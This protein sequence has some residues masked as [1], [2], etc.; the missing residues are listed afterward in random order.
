MPAAADPKGYYRIM[1]VPPTAS[2]EDIRIAFRERAKIF[3]PDQGNERANGDQFRL[4][5][6]A[7]D[8]LRDARKRMQYDAERLAV[9]EP[10][11]P[12]RPRA[13]VVVERDVNWLFSGRTLSLAA[14]GLAV[15]CLVLL[16]LLWS[17][18]NRLAERDAEADDLYRRL[19]AA[20]QDQAD[21]RARYRGA[22]F[23]R[24]EEALASSSS[25]GSGSASRFVFQAEIEFAADSSTIDD[26]LRGRLDAA[27]L[28]LARTISE[29]P[30][31]RDW[32]ILLEGHAGEAARQAGVSVGAWEM[33]LLRLGTVVDYL[34]ANGMP[35]Q[36]LAVR[37][38]AGFQPVGEAASD[39]GTVELKLLCCYR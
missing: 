15:A 11:R 25:I 12:M 21:V 34:V 17:A 29:I 28:D 38:Q 6:E 23:M 8:N 10:K 18:E 19:A 7:Y 24:L 5:R 31:D 2:A 14:G 9:E 39:G 3:H 26:K 27:V 1:G 30:A 16:G 36:R 22:N 33:S 37:F 20:M 32:L 4:L 35:T 13:Q